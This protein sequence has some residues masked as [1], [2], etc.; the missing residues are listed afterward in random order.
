VPTSKSES[1]SQ[2]SERLLTIKDVARMLTMPESWV[3]EHV[4]P[5]AKDRIPG[6]R[7]GKYW[8]FYEADVVAWLEEHRN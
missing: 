6:F 8:R 3:Y 5:K 7:L 4:K 2:E 1:R